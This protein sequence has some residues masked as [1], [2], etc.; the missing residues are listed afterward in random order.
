MNREKEQQY[1]DEFE[2]ICDNS[3]QSCKDCSIFLAEN[4]RHPTRCE[5]I[6]FYNKGR[7]DAYKELI[8][9]C[10]NS[11]Y[12]CHSSEFANVLEDWLKDKNNKDL[13]E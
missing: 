10:K 7:E 3:S 1:Y 11:S 5:C 12:T 9:K 4:G 2:N 13:A 8:E 6:F